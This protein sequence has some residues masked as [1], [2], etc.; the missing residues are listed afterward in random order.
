MAR[1]FDFEVLRGFCSSRGICI[2]KHVVGV[3]WWVDKRADV[4]VMQ[5]KPAGGA[6]TLITT[7][8]PSP[9]TSLCPIYGKT[10][11]C[12]MFRDYNMTVKCIPV[13]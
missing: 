6:D 4:P 3:C 2:L 8:P 7:N 10:A 11:L 13:L 5:P 12:K 9:S 1:V